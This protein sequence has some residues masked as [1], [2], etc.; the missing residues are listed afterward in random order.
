MS[1]SARVSKKFRDLKEKALASLGV[2]SW[3]PGAQPGQPA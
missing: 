3:K 2:A 1:A